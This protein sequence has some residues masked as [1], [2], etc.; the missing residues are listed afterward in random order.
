M[1]C[2]RSLWY[3]YGISFLRRV[4]LRHPLPTLRGIRHYLRNRDTQDEACAGSSNAPLSRS[5]HGIPHRTVVGLGF[6][7]KP[8]DPEC[9]SGRA[10]HL[11]EYLERLGASE[12]HDGSPTACGACQI[13]ELGQTALDKGCAVYVMTSARDILFDVLLPALE[14]RRFENAMLA[15][16]QYSFEPFRIA[17]AVVGLKARLFSFQS[18]DCKDY[19]TWLLADRGIKHEQTCFTSSHLVELNEFLASGS[20][21]GPARFGKVGNVFFPEGW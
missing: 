3:E 7:L 4:V 20:E 8:L 18:G 14:E 21:S 5:P 17:L 19:Q 16:C 6:C 10:N 15:L 9:P 13:R 2:I 1:F 12:K 11:C